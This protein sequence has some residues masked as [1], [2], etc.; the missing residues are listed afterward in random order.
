MSSATRRF[1][2]IDGEVREVT[3][4]APAPQSAIEGRRGLLPNS[5]DNIEGYSIGASIPDPTPER[6]EE[7]NK[8]CREN[9][10]TGVHFNPHYKHNCRVTDNRHFAKFLKLTG[11]ENVDGGFHGY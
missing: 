1:R 7:A 10:F 11:K 2:F 4:Q 3:D 8:I 6:I 5:H 9:G